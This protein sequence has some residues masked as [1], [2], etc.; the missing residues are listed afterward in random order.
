MS[1]TQPQ[2]QA[3]AP[4]QN[5]DQSIGDLLRESNRAM[6]QIAGFG[7]PVPAINLYLESKDEGTVLTSETGGQQQN[8]NMVVASPVLSLIAYAQDQERQGVL[9]TD[10]QKDIMRDEALLLDKLLEQARILLSRRL[11]WLGPKDE[12]KLIVHNLG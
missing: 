9:I 11:E 6:S 8:A 4:E 12:K 10:E 1:D 7:Y 3:Q 5:I 2:E